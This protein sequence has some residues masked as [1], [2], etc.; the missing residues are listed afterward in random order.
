VREY[1]IDEGRIRETTT[2]AMVTAVHSF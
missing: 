2:L 1:D